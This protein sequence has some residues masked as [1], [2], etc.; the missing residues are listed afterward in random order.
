MSYF[1]YIICL[2]ISVLF[3]VSCE[4]LVEEDQISDIHENQF[5]SELNEDCRLMAAWPMLECTGTIVHDVSGK[6]NHGTIYGATWLP[7]GGLL[8]DGVNDYIEVENA[9]SLNPV[10]GI[11][12]AA[13]YRTVSFHG[14]G[15]N[16]IIEKPYVIHNLPFYQYHLGV[17]G[18]QYYHCQASFTF[19]LSIEGNWVQ[20][21]T[22]NFYWQPNRWY[23]IVGTY[24]GFTVRLYVNGEL[25]SSCAC[26][27]SI[28]VYNTPL[29]MAGFVNLP[30]RTP[31]A[32]F[33]AFVCDR[34]LPDTEIMDIYYSRDQIFDKD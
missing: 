10:K 32:I 20:I 7:V 16:V 26:T 23:F 18:D 9:P 27:G 6:G 24:D 14:C 31:G 11:T 8:F 4:G 21:K 19:D 34:A 5:S 22:P 1:R 3:F 30:N 15:N 13:W 2:V 29:R 17:T 25:T 28:D 33:G 12:V